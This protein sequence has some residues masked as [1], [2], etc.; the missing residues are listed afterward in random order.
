[1]STTVIAGPLSSSNVL[2]TNQMPDN[3]K[4]LYLLKPYQTPLMQKLYFSQRQ[5]EAVTDAT[6]LFSWFEDVLYPHQIALSGAGIAGGSASETAIGLAE[7]THAA[8][9]DIFLVEDTEEMVYVNSIAGGDVDITSM[10]GSNIT[11]CTTG[12]I[13]KIGSRNSEYDTARIAQ[14]TQEVKLSNYLNI[15]SETVAMTGREQAAKHFTNG[16]SMKE[17][18]KKKV[19]EMKQQFER[20]FKFS[21]G[22]GTNTAGTYSYTWGKGF[23]GLVTTNKVSYTSVTEDSFDAF[24]ATVF[25]KGSRTRDLYCGTNLSVAI[26]K[27]VKDK[28]QV[29]GIPAKEY[30]IDLMRYILPFGVVNIIF[31]PYMDGKFVDYGFAVDWESVKLRYMAND[32]KGSR[33]FRIEENV[34][35]P[36][37]DGKAVKIIA[38][39]GFQLVNESTQGIYYK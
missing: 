16:R 34:E 30:G 13:K 14:S 18:I 5:S 23:L 9:G 28:Y 36:G 3:D 38:D 15:F 32:E 20:N 31:D 29:T 37:T 19:E 26:N 24:F 25:G 11:A 10:D 17:Q 27:I 4:L 6:G 12:Y 8:A 35:T 21:T 39:L 33:K 22:S 7:S 2:S 1:M